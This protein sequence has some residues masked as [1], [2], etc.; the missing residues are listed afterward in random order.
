MV[1]GPKKTFLED[2]EA[3]SRYM[4]KCVASLNHRQIEVD[5]SMRYLTTF[6]MAVFEKMWQQTLARMQRRQI[7]PAI[8][9]KQYGGSSK[10]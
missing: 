5:S 3:F 6:K 9:E 4:K 2:T 8:T 1:K 10:T 7:A